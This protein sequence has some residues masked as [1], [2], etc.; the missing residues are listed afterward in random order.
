MLGEDKNL[1]LLSDIYI[2]HYL[3]RNNLISGTMFASLNCFL[4]FTPSL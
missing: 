2:L 1:D 3:E 4:A